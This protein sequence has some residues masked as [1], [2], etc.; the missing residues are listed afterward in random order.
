M[1]TNDYM[2]GSM[3]NKKNKNSIIELYR[4]V[5]VLI[6][7]AHH[8]GVT[9]IGI[10]NPF[11]DG[12]IFTEFFMILT[13]YLTC[14]HYDCIATDDWSISKRSI[15]YTIKK[16]KSLMPYYIGI[17]VLA[18]VTTNYLVAVNGGGISGFVRGFFGDF[19]FDVLM[20]SEVYSHPGVAPLWYVAALAIV[21][22]IFAIIVQI[23]DKYFVMLIS[24][25]YPLM[26]YGF[27]GLYGRR[28]FP[29]D[30]L[31]LLAGLMLGA[32]VYLLAKELEKNEITINKIVGN[33]LLFVT[34]IFPI[35]SCYSNKNQFW[36]DLLCM[37]V[38]VGLAFSNRCF[39]V[40]VSNSI[41]DFLGTI[42]M[43]LF[44]IHWYVGTLVEIGGQF[45]PMTTVVKVVLY[46]VLS[47]AMSI[48]AWLIVNTFSKKRLGNEVINSS[49][50]L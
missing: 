19:I 20:I 23:K 44:M 11:F 1:V 3:N 39:A 7:M 24:L 26:Y 30:Y 14:K 49:S 5:A 17:T 46:Y 21:F 9:G 34:M 40:R 12:W 35:A 42:T 15:Y 13:G 8:V 22:P 36:L 33:V 29:N 31:R 10:D 6:I 48:I 16:L 41:I 45:V 4:F 43:P 2:S 38:M 18:W 25:V 32:F 47:I 37:V 27:A 50:S 28:D